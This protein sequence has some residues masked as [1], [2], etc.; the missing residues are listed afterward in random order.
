MRI[1]IPPKQK[2][3]L[4]ENNAYSCCICKKKNIG[5]NFHH[6]D[7][8]HSN[9]EDSNIAVLCVEEHD[10]HHRPQK[11][12][13]S[14]HLELSAECIKEKKLKWEQFVSEA[15]KEEPDIIAVVTAYGQ[16]ENIQGMKIVF[17]WTDGTIE[18]ER[19]YH[20]LNSPMDIW[21]D[22]ALEEINWLGKYIKLVLINEP[23]SIEYCNECNSTYSRTLD[24]GQALKV[25][26]SDWS[27]KSIATIYFNPIFSSLA[28]SI[29]YDRELLYS[30]SIHKCNTDY[31]FSDGVCEE[32]YFAYKNNNK[33][34]VIELLNKKLDD[35]ECGRIII[36][37]GDEI[38]P[39][40]IDEYY[41]HEKWFNNHISTR[42]GKVI[43]RK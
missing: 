4:L 30:A 41:F 37:T 36:G 12:T 15:K 19:T 28:Y 39:T 22:K 42:A 5:F 35:W 31:V 10:K 26:K 23:L 13:K 32:R 17:Q 27:D 20:S 6:I 33:S 14:S 21:I 2:T 43:R 34:Q 29:F 8:N 38:N 9:N 1:Q 40:I 3:R 18:F 7:G 24:R 11:Y 25:T 16:E